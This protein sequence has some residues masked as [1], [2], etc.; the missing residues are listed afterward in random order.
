MA[1]LEV[2]FLVEEH[3]GGSPPNGDDSFLS[4]GPPGPQGPPGLYEPKNFM[5]YKYLKA[6][7]D[8]KD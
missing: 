3:P 2:V 4:G 5:D 7:K 1:L 6:L 8:L